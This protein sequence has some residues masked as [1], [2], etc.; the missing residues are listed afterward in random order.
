MTEVTQITPTEI[1]TQVYNPQ[2]VGLVPSFEVNTN[3]TEDSYIEY[4]VYDLDNN[5]LH[6]DYSFNSY[7]I[8]N[9][10]QSSLDGEISQI[11]IN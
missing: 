8:L 4:N 9:D 1:T 11:Q 3:L 2:D 7:S 6:T 5:L 10:G